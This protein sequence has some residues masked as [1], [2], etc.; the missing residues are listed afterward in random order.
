MKTK[1]KTKRSLLAVMLIVLTMLAG[2]AWPC[3]AFAATSCT[4]GVVYQNGL[5]GIS[6][7]INKAPYNTIF[8]D[9][10]LQSGYGKY[11]YGPSGC[12]WFASARARELT[13]KTNVN[14]I[15]GAEYWWTKGTSLGFKKL[16][17]GAKLQHKAIAVWYPS[18]THPKVGH[19]AVVEKVNGSTVIL[20]EGGASNSWFNSRPNLQPYGYCVL[21]KTTQAQLESLGKFMGYID[22]GVG[23]QKDVVPTGLTLPSTANVD[24]N[25]TVQLNVTFKPSNTTKKGI[26]WTTSNKSVA[27]VD[28]SG[29]VRGLKAG[30]A[31]ITAVS[32]ANTKAKASCTVTVSGKVLSTSL[33]ISKTS[34]SLD[35]GKSASLSATVNPSNA[36]NKTVT[37][38]SSDKS[39]ATVDSK[40]LVKAV[41][42]GLCKITAA[43]G[44]GRSRAEC[45]VTVSLKNGG[46]YRLKHVGTGKMMN[47]AWGWKEFQYKPIFLDKRD[48]S[49]EQTFRF[50][51]I[52]GGKYEIDIMHR[53]GGVMNVWT[54]K[55]VAAG[56]KIGSW[57]KTND[58]TQ[59]FYVTPVGGGK[60]ILRSAQN[61]NLAV[62]PDGSTRGYL[63]LVNYNAGDKNQ[64]W[65][66][67]FVK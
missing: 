53:E 5:D 63:K 32:T 46:V 55:T 40:G 45:T 30:R 37:W 19:V 62:A 41:G 57:T 51:H 52:S 43:S 48:G 50:R 65:T 42:A 27:T 7:S 36:S 21:R 66:L 3:S 56:Q 26:T 8:I 9:D 12:A 16:Y 60:F 33:S 13:N 58:D 31:T 22:L 6:I 15:W 47:Y 44:D 11:A 29:K 54:S 4:K 25:G 59:R 18:T 34:L 38:T 14:L 2:L 17:R 28:S 64:Q 49:V 23:F 20:S 61:R 10:R 39:V 24:I 67:E 35:F 1:M